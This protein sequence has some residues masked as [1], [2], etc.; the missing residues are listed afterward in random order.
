MWAITNL[1]LDG[2]FQ[3]TAATESVQTGAAPR[4]DLR[5]GHKAPTFIG[6]LLDGKSVKFPDDYKGKIVLLDFWATW[7]HAAVQEIPVVKAYGK[8]HDQGLEVLGVSLDKKDGEQK[9]ADFIKSKNMPWPQVYDGKCWDAGV[10]VLY[11]VDRIS[12]RILVDGDT[13]VILADGLNDE[14]IAPAIEE[15]L[16]KKNKK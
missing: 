8:Y 6:K 15:A 1:T 2:A 12:Y 4:L 9:L 14:N 13:G 16:A 7:C 5:L 10:A 3:I 11:G